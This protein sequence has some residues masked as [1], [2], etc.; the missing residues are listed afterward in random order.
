MI[1]PGTGDVSTRAAARSPTSGH[2]QANGIRFAYLEQGAGPLV[3]LLH[4]FPDNAWTYRRQLEVLSRAGYRAV[5]P[6]LRGYAPTEIPADGRFDPATL[7]RDVHGL[8][9]ALSATGKAFVVGMDWVARPRTQP[10]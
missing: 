3:L 9:R 2:V 1:E 6:F 10:W 5:A 8:I 4:G 7:G